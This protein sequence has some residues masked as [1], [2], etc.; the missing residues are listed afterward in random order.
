MAAAADGAAMVSVTDRWRMTEQLPC[1]RIAAL[2]L[3]R[4]RKPWGSW[5]HQ[6]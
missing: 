5:G 3:R 4:L 6:S 2:A 1:L